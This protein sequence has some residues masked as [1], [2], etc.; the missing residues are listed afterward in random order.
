[1]LLP[2]GNPIKCHE[3]VLSLQPMFSPTSI[4]NPI[5]CHEEVL[6]L[7][8]MFSPT[9]IYNPIKCHEEV[10]SLQ[11][12][13]QYHLLVSTTRFDIFPPYEVAAQKN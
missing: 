12:M 11:P 9:S 1:M 7:Q 4:Y 10:L 13:F 6:S 5:K 3:E 2:L 8:P